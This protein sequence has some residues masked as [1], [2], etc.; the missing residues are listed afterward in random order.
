MKLSRE[1]GTTQIS[2]L[3]ICHLKDGTTRDGA[4]L[5][6]FSGEANADLLE[7]RGR[8]DLSLSHNHLSSLHLRQSNGG[9]RA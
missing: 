6:R 4:T 7:T 9:N 5:S 1:L 8:Y 2:A 3:H